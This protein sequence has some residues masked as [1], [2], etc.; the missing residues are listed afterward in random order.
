MVVQMGWVH[1]H[2]FCADF[3]GLITC[4]HLAESYQQISALAGIR[5]LLIDYTETM[6]ADETVVNNDQLFASLS[7]VLRAPDFHCCIIVIPGNKAFAEYTRQLGR[8]YAL[9]DRLHIVRS[10]AAGIQVLE[11]CLRTGSR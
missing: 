7:A 3:A 9:S 11:N 6:F 1:P 10:R 2:V 4:E 5:G 8:Q